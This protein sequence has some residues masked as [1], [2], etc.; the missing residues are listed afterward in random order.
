MENIFSSA[1]IKKRLAQE[2]SDF[3][4]VNKFMQ[5]TMRKLN[6]NKNVSKMLHPSD[7]L[8]K[9]K[10]NKDSLNKI[11]KALENYLEEKRSNIFI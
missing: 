2:S 10:K 9:F 7:I 11:Q 5:E 1:D 3:E 8:T 6:Q 4:K